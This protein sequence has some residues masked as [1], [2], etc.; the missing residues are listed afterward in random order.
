MGTRHLSG[1]WSLTAQ[2]YMLDWLGDVTSTVSF[3][4]LSGGCV[5][6]NESVHKIFMFCIGLSDPTRCVNYAFCIVFE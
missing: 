4:Q 1:S 6:P 5:L 3:C 2:D